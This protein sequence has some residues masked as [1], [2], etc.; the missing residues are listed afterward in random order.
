MADAFTFLDT[1]DTSDS[2][3]RTVFVSAPDWVVAKTELGEIK[4]ERDGF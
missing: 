1:T 4:I 3:R 2:T